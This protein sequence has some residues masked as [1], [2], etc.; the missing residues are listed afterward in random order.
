VSVVVTS[1]T[2]VVSSSVMVGESAARRDT[3]ALSFMVGVS[4][5]ELLTLSVMVGESE[6]EIET[7]LLVISMTKRA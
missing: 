5:T 2:N 4:V 7:Q 3:I 6:P 1:L